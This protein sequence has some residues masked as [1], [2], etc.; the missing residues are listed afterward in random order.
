MIMDGIPT[1]FG[2]DRQYW[3]KLSAGLAKTV[4]IGRDYHRIQCGNNCI[5]GEGAYISHG[6][7][8]NQGVEFPRIRGRPPIS[9]G[10]ISEFRVVFP[11]DL[12]EAQRPKAGGVSRG[13]WAGCPANFGKTSNIGRDYPR[14]WLRPP[15]SGGLIRGSG[16]AITAHFGKIAYITM[17]Y[18][19]NQGGVLR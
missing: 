8:R 18:P 1:R 17:G 11:A 6:Y 16:A 19:R 14:V 10:A 13:I 2:I 12:G 5:C 7:P 9:G 3:E 4:N 15:I